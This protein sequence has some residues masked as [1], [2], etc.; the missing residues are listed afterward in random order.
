MAPRVL[1]FA[2]TFDPITVAHILMLRQCIETEFFDE[3]WVLPSGRRTDKSFK[4][5]DESRLEQCR[6]VVGELGVQHP[7]IKVCPY[8]VNLGHYIDSYFTMKYFKGKYPDY[9][10]YFFIGSDIL[11]QLLSWPFGKEFVEITRFL[12]A[13][14]EGYPIRKE[15]MDNLK[16]Y[17]LLSELLQRKSRIMKTSNASSTLVRQQLAEHVKCDEVGT[18]PPYVMQYILRNALYGT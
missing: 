10:F 6:M 12:I 9:E 14:R 11:P 7:K 18:L 4:A 2:G 5:S 17:E 8:E 13:D 15:D 1:L 3:I 16:Q